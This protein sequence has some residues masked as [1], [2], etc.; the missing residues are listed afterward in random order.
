MSGS[1]GIILPLSAAQREIWLAEQR[2][3][4]AKANRAYNVGEYI[5]IHGPV[6]PV[7]F[8]TALRQVVGEIDSLHVRFIEAG[9]GPRQILQPSLEWVMLF[10]DIS[11]DP[12]PMAAAH[13]WMTAEL[14]R[15]MDLARGPLFSYALIKLEPD[16][17]V[18]YQG[19]H[20]IVMDGFGFSL[21]ARRMAQTYTALVTKHAYAQNSFGS[22]RDLLDSDIAYRGSEQFTQDQEYWVKRFAD[23]PEPT[24]LVNRSST[25]PAILAHQTTRLSL[26]SM[27]RLTAAAYRAGVRWSRVVIAAAAVY[28]H[29]LTGARDV[30]V[31]LAVTARQDPIL[32]HVPGMVSNVL[33]LRLSIRPDMSPSDLIAY[34]DQEVRRMLA[35]QRYRGEDLYRDLGLSGHIAKSFAPLINIMSFDYDLRFAGHRATARNIFHG[36]IYDLAIVVLD[37]RDGSGFQIDLYANPEICGVDDVTAHHQRFL[38][39]LETITV[40]DP[41]RPISHIDLLT[42]QERHRLLVEYNDTAQAIP[43]ISLPALFH[44]QVHATPDTV[45]V[46]C[47]DTTLTYTQLNTRANQLAHTLIG[48]GVGRECA[49]AVLVERSVDLVVSILAVVKAGGVYVPLDTRYPLARME[50]VMAETAASVLVT[51][52]TGRARQFPGSAQ[53]VIIDGDPCLAELAEQDPGDPGITCDPEQLAYVMYTSGSTGQPKG[54]AVTH[55]N[56]VELAGDRCWRGGDHQRVLMHSPATFDAST[57]ELWVPLLTG[58]QIVVAPPGELGI[59]TLERVI[60]QNNVTGLWLTAG[61]FSLMAEQ[62]PGCF[63]G[64]RQVWAGGDV[65][66]A[67]AA[68]RVLDACPETRVVNGYGPTETTT[69]AARHPMR[70]PYDAAHAVPIGRPMANTR[71]YVLDAGLEPVPAGVAGE[72]YIAGAGLARGYLHRPGLT[73]QRFIADPFGPVGT[74]MYRS[75]DLARWRPDGNLEFVG[76]VDDQVKVRGFRIEPGEIETVLTAHPDVA[77]AAVIAREDQPQ[78]KRLVA[79]VVADTTS[80]VRDEQT[81]QDQVG[82]WA[83]I[84]DSLYAVSGSA[85]LGEDFTGWTS[86][87]DGQ[88]IPLAQ[89]RDWREQTLA[90]ILALQ[91]RR[92]LEVGVGTGLL[93]SHLAPRC[94][95]YWATDF[96]ASVINTLTSRISQDPELAARVVLRDQP[97][98]DTE[99]LPVELFDTVILNSIVQY[100]PSADYLLDVLTRMLQLLTP[101][102]TVFLGDVRNPRLLRALATAVQLRRVE[103]LTDTPTLRRRVEQAIRVEK[104]LLVDPE[105]FTALEARNTDIAG[106]DIQIKRGHHHNELTRYRYDVV[107]HKHPITPLPLGE[108]PRLDWGQQIDGLHELGDYLTTGRPDLVR[109][110][111]IPNK[112]ITHE[113]AA[114]RALQAGHPLADLL[115]HP[116]DVPD[117]IDPEAL[118]ALGERC[119]Y[120]VG[121]TWSTTT[122]DALDAVFT[123]PTHTRSVV[124]VDLYAPAIITNPAGIPLS[125][126]TNDPTAA[127]D[128]SALITALREHTRTRLPEYMLPTVFVTLDALPLTP[129]GKLDRAALPAPEFGSAG[130]GRAPRTPQEQLL[131]ELFAEVLGLAT[132]GVEDDFFVLGGHSL[133]ATR[134]IARIRVTLG[135]ELGLRSLFETPT[136]AGVA[137]HLGDAG[138]A[139]LALTRYE[140]PDRVPLSFAQRRLWFLHQMEGPS[141][142][143]NIPLALRLFGD[144]DQDA[145]QAA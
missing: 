43:A 97:A 1:D 58:G 81:E 71:V 41:N 128:T 114:A 94:E 141:A 142:T 34:V 14:A 138:Q 101:G 78:D 60:T 51:D 4:T 7:L 87:Y 50:W 9:D 96:S 76:R 22:L 17:C 27:D 105:F 125:S 86:S 35:H 19:Y 117:A 18:W 61:L 6:D 55:R 40:T 23:R 137:A 33:P 133:L 80:S 115:D 70:A 29:R 109:V 132:V 28:V 56:V 110:T 88:P 39:L 38:N 2:L 100:F 139:R 116:A 85:V 10:V 31:G 3:T 47:G 52:Q 75:G 122:P 68:A 12:D 32:R 145:L 53:V 135:V 54:I 121:L 111:G 25:T 140:R 42:T 8:E 46:I 21:V 92:V 124:P 112:R 16:R 62:C 79:Y 95:A 5:E 77:Q 118:H 24:R 73:A 90:R 37:R 67:A 59:H 113:A 134:L 72:L 103:G 26:F 20:H 65:V 44:A 11:D 129:N 36:S 30:V 74:R 108:A 123:H 136:V 127:R 89:M 126:F 104:E 102:G 130:T 120:W 66:S 49:V 107:L 15:Q 13:A 82:E 69:F 48:L 83:Q 93:L 84:Y 144:L 106:I 63:A 98:H 131:A 45:A 99:G 119:G 91:P 57:Y 143:Y 64:V